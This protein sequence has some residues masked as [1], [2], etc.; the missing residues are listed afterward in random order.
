MSLLMNITKDSGQKLV[1]SLLI[2]WFSYEELGDLNDT[3]K[4]GVITCIQKG[5][6]VC[7]QLKNEQLITLPNSTYNFSQLF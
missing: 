1:I 2:L 3:Q 7:N 4:A 5:D 6:N